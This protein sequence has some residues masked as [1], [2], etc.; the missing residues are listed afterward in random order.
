M[1]VASVLSYMMNVMFFLSYGVGCMQLFNDRNI[2]NRR[3]CDAFKSQMVAYGGNFFPVSSSSLDE[4]NR[5]SLMLDTYVHLAKE[6]W[7]R[8]H[9]YVRRLLT[10]DE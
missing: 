1:R 10:Y 6:C 4:M 2:E 3:E 8:M 7:R 5:F 9:T